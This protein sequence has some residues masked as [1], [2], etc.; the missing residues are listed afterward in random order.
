MKAIVL[1]LS[2]AERTEPVPRGLSAAD[3]VSLV[4]ALIDVYVSWRE[5]CAAVAGA[6]EDW[7]AAEPGDGKL[8]AQSSSSARGAGVSPGR[9]RRRRR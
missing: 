9:S 2:S 4:D 3:L 7:S 8:A 1:S 6:Y 5:E